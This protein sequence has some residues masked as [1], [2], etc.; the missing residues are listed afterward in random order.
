LGTIN[1][2]V[3]EVADQVLLIVAGRALPLHRAP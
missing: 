2:D 3:A 1:Q